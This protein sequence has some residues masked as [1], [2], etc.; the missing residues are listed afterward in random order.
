MWMAKRC[1][2]MQKEI[3]ATSPVCSYFSGEFVH[4]ARDSSLMWC[5]SVYRIPKHITCPALPRAAVH[6]THLNTSELFF[7]LSLWQTFTFFP[8]F[9]FPHWAGFINNT[10]HSLQGYI[11]NS[12]LPFNSLSQELAPSRE[13]VLHIFSS[14]LPYIK[15]RMENNAVTVNTTREYIH[16]I[17]GQASN[18]NFCYSKTL[19]LRH[20]QE[21]PLFL[22]GQCSASCAKSNMASR[23]AILVFNERTA[24][25]VQLWYVSNTANGLRLLS[26]MSFLLGIMR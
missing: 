14:L 12:K 6:G 2:P 3:S 11:L 15:K 22:W 21:T 8:F 17:S 13:I 18:T 25:V 9:F 10:L 4:A 7:P 24:E 26:H 23:Q 5:R 19:P 1:N 16:Y 20:N